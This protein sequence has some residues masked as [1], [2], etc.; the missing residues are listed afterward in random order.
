M[1]FA[2]V[3]GGTNQLTSHQDPRSA[4]MLPVSHSKPSKFCLRLHGQ[5]S[6]NGRQHLSCQEKGAKSHLPLKFRHLIGF[7]DFDRF[8]RGLAVWG[9]S[10]KMQQQYFEEH[11]L[12]VTPVQTRYSGDI[13]QVQYWYGESRIMVDAVL[14]TWNRLVGEK[15]PSLL[16][17]M[18]FFGAHCVLN[19]LMLG[20]IEASVS[21]VVEG[22]KLISKNRMSLDLNEKCLIL[23]EARSWHSKWLW[24]N[25]SCEI[26]EFAST[27]TLPWG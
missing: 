26:P 3:L 6:H 4:V 11:F 22:C 18:D 25:P 1:L 27:T 12:Y 16:M 21:I 20:T 19:V 5:T 14:T 15:H 9:V 2:N 7:V 13:N 23:L 8:R 10:S 17:L 24:K